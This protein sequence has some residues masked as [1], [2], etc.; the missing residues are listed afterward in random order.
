M[1]I[2][3]KRTVF[4]VKQVQTTSPCGYPQM[5]SGILKNYPCIVGCKAFRLSGRMPEPVCLL[6]KFVEQY[7]S[8]GIIA[9]PYPVITVFINGECTLQ[10]NIGGIL[11]QVIVISETIPVISA[12][13]VLGAKPHKPIPVLVNAE[14]VVIG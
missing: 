1:N 10:K 13:T 12:D 6:T 14:H 3:D 5:L 4:S 8:V 7:Q 9:E 11:D 2:M